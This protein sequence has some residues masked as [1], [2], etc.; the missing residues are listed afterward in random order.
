VVNES[1]EK[2]EVVVF[3]G[4]S[5]GFRAVGAEEVARRWRGAREREEGLGR[6]RVE[7]LV[8]VDAALRGYDVFTDAL[9]AF[10]HM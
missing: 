6:W 5:V 9:D 4:W 8:A 3:E 7:D 2:V 1:E 10:V